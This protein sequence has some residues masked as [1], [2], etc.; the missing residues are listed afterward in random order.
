MPRLRRNRVK[1]GE[2]GEPGE[3]GATNVAA[4]D[5]LVPLTA[6]RSPLLEVA[7][8]FLRLGFTAFGG[9]AAHVAMMREEVVQRR[10]WLNDA[11]FLDLVGVTNLIPGPNSTELAIYLGYLRA[12]RRGL[13]IAGL[14]FIGPAMLIVMALAW[15]YVTYGGL[16][17]VGWLFYGIRPVVVGVVAQALF[18]LGGTVLALDLLGTSPLLLLV[19]SGLLF[20]AEHTIQ[21]APENT[22]VVAGM[23]TTGAPDSNFEFLP[24]LLVLG[25]MAT[26]AGI[27]VRRGKRS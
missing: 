22:P 18:R 10:R 6:T 12:G 23:P 13:V 26:L 8:L 2:P 7:G 9:P 21:L 5:L 27:M 3:P 25:S 4:E 16:P 14:C 1:P 20:A 19:G 15:A 11:Q 17:E 24:L